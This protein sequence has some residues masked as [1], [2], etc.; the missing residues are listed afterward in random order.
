MSSR[1]TNDSSSGSGVSY[2]AG[3]AASGAVKNISESKTADAST[4]SLVAKSSPHPI[5]VWA[6]GSVFD[7]VTGT[8]LLPGRDFNPGDTQRR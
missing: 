3:N 6:D 8:Y 2:A 7:T 5:E 1:Q 4:N